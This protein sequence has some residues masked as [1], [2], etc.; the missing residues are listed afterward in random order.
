MARRGIRRPMLWAAIGIVLFFAF[1]WADEF[2]TLA[3]GI[4]RT[5]MGLGAGIAIVG[6]VTAEGQDRIRVPRW[7]AYLGDA[8]YAI[9]LVHVLA[10]SIGAKLLVASHLAAALP[11]PVSAVLL[12]AGSLAAGI[13]LHEIVEKRLMRLRPKRSGPNLGAESTG[14]PTP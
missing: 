5:T 1:A 4:T 13:V 8:S 6:L 9:Y 7:L 12:I 11:R 10:L 2:T 14:T 3:R